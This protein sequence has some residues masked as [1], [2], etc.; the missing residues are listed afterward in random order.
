MQRAHVL[1][2]LQAQ[3][4]KVI[5]EMNE[6]DLDLWKYA[7]DL[8]VD[9]IHMQGSFENYLKRSKDNSSTLLAKSYMSE[10]GFSCFKA[11]PSFNTAMPIPKYLVKQIGIFR[12]P[13]HK[14][15]L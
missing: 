13:L 4:T 10:S 12:P 15:P 2:M 9:R 6:L 1:L 3:I 14:G 11:P 8:S 5:A 7:L